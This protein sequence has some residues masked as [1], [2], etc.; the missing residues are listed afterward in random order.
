M[1]RSWEL[2]SS[3]LGVLPPLSVVPSCP[4]PPQLGLEGAR[5][6]CLAGPGSALIQTSDLGGGV[7]QGLLLGI[8]CQRPRTGHPVS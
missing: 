1:N 7:L 2:G 8:H 4:P 3:V 5:G 6:A